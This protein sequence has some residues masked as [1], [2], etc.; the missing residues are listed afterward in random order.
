MNNPV[1]NFTKLE[2]IDCYAVHCYLLPKDKYPPY[3][4]L[5]G[6]EQWQEVLS[7]YYQG[8][9]IV[10]QMRAASDHS[11]VLFCTIA[12]HFATLHCNA[13][14]FFTIGQVFSV[15][16]Q[17]IC[18]I[19]FFYTSVKENLTLNWTHTLISDG[20]WPQKRINPNNWNHRFW[21]LLGF[22][23]F[24]NYFLTFF[25]FFNFRE[26]LIFLKSKVFCSCF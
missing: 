22:C 3:T 13:I 6:S 10:I 24:R 25:F 8:R 20:S 12:M 4:V 15:Y 26:N 16:F 17:K 18:N 21:Q 23:C 11:T 19:K 1:S 7:L 2:F 9:R 5:Q 14:I